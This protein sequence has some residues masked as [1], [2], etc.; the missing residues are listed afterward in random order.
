MKYRVSRDTEHT[1]VAEYNAIE[2]TLEGSPKGME[3]NKSYYSFEQ[4]QLIQQ[5]ID[6]FESEQSILTQMKFVCDE[7]DRLFPISSGLFLR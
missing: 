5:Q 7:R 6:L 1:T 2:P 3:I 4:Q